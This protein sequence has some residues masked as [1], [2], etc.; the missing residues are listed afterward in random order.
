MPSTNPKQALDNIVE[1]VDEPRPRQIPSR[2][3]QESHERR[4]GKT[5][6]KDIFLVR[7]RAWKVLATHG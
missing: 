6:E 5:D 1:A 4:Q 2:I 3:L 7:S